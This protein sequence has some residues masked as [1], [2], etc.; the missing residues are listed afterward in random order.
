MKLKHIFAGAFTAL[1]AMS[2]SGCGDNSDPDAVD[3][4]NLKHPSNLKILDNGDKTATLTWQA[5]NFEGKF[6]GYNVYGVKMSDTEIADLSAKGLAKGTPLQLLSTDGDPE[7]NAKEILSKFNYDFDNPL[8]AAKLSVDDDGVRKISFLPIHNRT[9][10]SAEPV[11]PTCYPTTTTNRITTCTST[12]EASDTSSAFANGTVTYTVSG[13]TPGDQYCFL[14]FSVQD[15]G[16]EISQT[17]TNVECVTP[18]YINT[19]FLTQS[20]TTATTSLAPRA[21]NESREFKIRDYATACKTAGTCPDSKLSTYYSDTTSDATHE[22]TGDIYIET[23]SSGTAFITFTPGKDCGIL[24]MGYITS[25][26]DDKLPAIAPSFDNAYSKG[27]SSVQNSNGYNAAGQSLIVKQDN[28][29]ILACADSSDTTKKYYDW[30]LVRGVDN[31][32][33]TFS[34]PSAT[35]GFD[36]FRVDMRVS[37]TSR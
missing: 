1:L 5:S 30:I 2:Y 9:A 16:E 22:S 8:N 20:P 26:S 25:L 31:G 15:D 32:D 24:D 34:E 18:K 37:V 3:V 29:Y 10:A 11:L 35:T 21:N 13:L 12:E 7:P 27:T 23:F 17:S 14:V 6:E 33:G 28:L 4:T 36:T 19:G